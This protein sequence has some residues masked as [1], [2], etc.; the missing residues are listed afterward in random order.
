MYILL[1]TCLNIRAVHL[2]LVNDMSTHSVVLAMVRFFNL[3]GVPT[4]IYSDNARSFVAGCDLVKQVFVSDEFVG[5]FS[6][7]NIKHLTIPLYSAWFGSVWER[8]IKTVKSCL[9]KLVGR[10]SLEYFEVLTVLS[11]V[12]NAINSRPL[13]YR[14]SEDAGLD[15]I[16][17]NAFLHPHFNTSLFLR[18]QAVVQ[19]LTPPSREDLFGSLEF[20]D[21]YLKGFHDLWYEE[22][23]LSIREQSRDLFQVEYHNVIRVGDVVVVKNPIK[24]RPYWSLGRVMEVTPGDDALVRSAKIR[25]PDG[26]EQE[27]S[28]KHLY[29][30]ELSIT[31][32]H[33]AENPPEEASVSGVLTP[34]RP[35][36]SVRKMRRGDDDFLWY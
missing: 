28:I 15:V 3:Y 10:K 29:P 19:E 31:H 23:L 26:R 27:Y 9:F 11:D 7:F 30:L 12:Q 17:P 22:Y 1:F 35:T 14:C 6:T 16:T 13:T 21:I 20:R 24:S 33:Q 18:D 25:R 34:S 2:E 32:S 4:H 5:K 36:R 8:L